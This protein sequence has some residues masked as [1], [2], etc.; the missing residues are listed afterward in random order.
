MKKSKERPLTRPNQGITLIALVITIIVLLILAGVSL[1]L[2]AGSDGILG[3]ASSATAQTQKATAKEQVELLLADYKAEY[4]Q[5]KYVDGTENG[6]PKEYVQAKLEPG[7][8]TN[9]Y[10]AKATGDKVKV[11][12]G[13]EATGKAVAQGTL[14][15]N[16]GIRWEDPDPILEEANSNPEKFRHPEQQTSTAIG[17]GPHGEPVNMDL[18]VYGKVEEGYGLINEFYEGSGSFSYRSAY[19][20]TDFENI[21]IPQYIKTEEEFKPVTSL[22]YTFDVCSQI[23]KAPEIPGTVTDMGGTFSGCTGLT[24]A[25]EIPD[26]VTYMGNTFQNCTGLT[27]APEIPGTVTNISGAFS[28]CTGLTVAPEIPD[29]VTYMNDTFSRCTGLTVAPKIPGSVTSMNGTFSRCTGLTVAPEIPGSV[30]YMERTFQDC[31]AL[32]GTVKI[33]A[34]NCNHMGYDSL[35]GVFGG[36][37]NQLTVQV[38]ANSVTYDTIYALYKDS[39]N[40]TIETF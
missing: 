29:S 30:T 12:P 2:M 24:V 25:P 6:N 21:I 11:Y 20:G 15:E 5:G 23:T 33:N 34:K 9:N 26:S 38:P 1:S 4:F 39:S 3:K 7:V 37:T 32:T 40:I 13:S 27:I 16:G 31:T 10:F 22:F 8:A 36:I 18:W 28:G 17:V 35:V 14:L 19:L